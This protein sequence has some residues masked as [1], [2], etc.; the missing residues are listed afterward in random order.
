MLDIPFTLTLNAPRVLLYLGTVDGTV[1]IGVG[2]L[3]IATGV[4]IT[5][6]GRVLRVCRQDA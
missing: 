5:S 4:G 6:N 1:E 3:M 2:C